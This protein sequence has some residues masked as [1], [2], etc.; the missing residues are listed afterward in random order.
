MI[1]NIRTILI[2]LIWSAAPASALPPP[3][4]AGVTAV[5]VGIADHPK[6]IMRGLRGAGHAI[7]KP[8]KHKR[9]P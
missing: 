3:S 7:A 6:L 1:D 2:Y 9:K 5:L 8:F 4:L